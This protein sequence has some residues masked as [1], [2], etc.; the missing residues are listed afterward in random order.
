[1]RPFTVAVSLA[2]AC[3]PVFS[4]DSSC[5]GYTQD[6]NTFFCGEYGNCTW[7]ASY[8]RPDL[9]G[10]IHGNAHEWYANARD[11]LGFD[12]GSEPKI[13]SIAVFSSP[14]HVAY[15]EG[16]SDDGSFSA[17]EMDYS[18]KLGDGVQYATYNP[19]SGGYQRNG[20]GKVWRLTGFIYWGKPYVCENRSN[21]AM[22]CWHVGEEDRSC[23]NGSDWTYI[24]L[25]RVLYLR[26]EPTVC[27]DFLDG[28]DD[29]IGGGF[30]SS[31]PKPIDGSDNEG[32]LPNLRVLS[33][34]L[35]DG[36]RNR[37]DRIRVGQ[38]AYCGMRIENNGSKDVKETFQ[39]SCYLSKGR[40]PDESPEDLGKED[41]KK[42]KKGKTTTEHEDFIAP[43]FPGTYSGQ[44]CV[45]SGK[46]VKEK[47]EKDNCPD[48]SFVFEVWSEP[49]IVVTGFDVPLLMEVRSGY[50]IEADI[51]NTGEN[52]GKHILVAYFWDGM[53]IGFDRIKKEHLLAGQVKR[54]TLGDKVPVIVPDDP[55]LHMVTVCGDYGNRIHY[56][57][58]KLDNCLSKTVIVYRPTDF[59]AMEI[60]F[61]K[62]EVI[63][64][65]ETF[66]PKVSFGNSGLEVDGYV[67]VTHY[68]DGMLVATDRIKGKN[69]S[70][71]AVKKEAIEKLSIPTVGSH[72][73]KS[74]INESHFFSEENWDNNCI[75]RL[76]EVV[77]PQ[78][79]LSTMPARLP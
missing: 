41:T 60:S 9:K 51:A 25:E 70:S 14:S 66:T 58:S 23:V 11:D 43:S 72:T 15:V 4:G 10:I 38:K 29:G 27:S 65:D 63:E 36:N 50:R 12:V 13:G 49:N 18:G 21:Y 17:S 53:P 5:K 78:G 24:D 31:G 67:E 26:V 32:S 33:Q 69:L 71:G 62:E 40:K 20:G 77:A 74:C 1:M 19:V 46:D 48:E 54:E 56:E 76:V 8:K 59:S 79:A 73:I 35:E 6:G 45:D 37:I 68:L 42:L 64:V 28:N 34:W 47:H 44:A 7:W 16:A 2:L 75:E 22:L 57:T 3:G 52:V 30:E 39:T 55:G 61:G